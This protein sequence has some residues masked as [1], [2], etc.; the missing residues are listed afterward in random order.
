M[1]RNFFSTPNVIGRLMI[2]L[3][4][5]GGVFYAGAFDGFVV[6]TKASGCCGGGTDI[7]FA[8]DSSYG[9][10]DVPSPVTSCSLCNSGSCP[11]QGCP[12]S[13]CSNGCGAKMVC[14]DSCTSERHRNC[15]CTN[16]RQKKLC[17]FGSQCNPGNDCE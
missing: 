17:S 5:V 6:E 16:R 1:I 10:G 14:P 13:S 11:G 4:F 9:I 2:V 3:L 7:A 12:G 15:D 8:L